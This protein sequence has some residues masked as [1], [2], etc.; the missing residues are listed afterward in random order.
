M[1]KCYACDSSDIKLWLD[2]FEHLYR[3][4][5][6][7]RA[8]PYRLV[9]CRRCGLGFIDPMPDEALVKTFYQSNYACYSQDPTYDPAREHGKYKMAR[10]RFEGSFNRGGTALSAFKRIAAMTVEWGSGKTISY[11]LGVPLQLP[12]DAKIFEVGYGSGHWLYNMA[13]LGYKNLHGYDIDGNPMSGGK[14]QAAG[15]TIHK[16]AFT[17]G[18]VQEGAFDCIRLEHVFEHLL[19]PVE[20]L[21]VLGRM[22]KPDGFLVMTFPCKDSISRMLS[23]RHWGP[24]EPPVHIYHHTPKSAR[25]MLRKANLMPLKVKPYPVI[26]QLAGTLNN[27]L[28]VR[29]LRTRLV[30][31]RSFKMLAPAYG[32]ISKVTMKGDFMTVLAKPKM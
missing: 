15:V 12:P 32:M 18:G 24:L 17:G 14:L 31:G 23:S 26:E 4:D 30:T 29:G 7:E 8:W 10:M 19:K 22:L 16:D 5:G 6:R 9:E 2:G 3:E 11:S 20:V 28:V 21:E 27:L 1:P 13:S 25:L